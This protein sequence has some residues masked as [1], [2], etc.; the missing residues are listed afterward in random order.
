MC[1][2]AVLIAAAGCGTL[3][4]SGAAD[5]DAPGLRLDRSAPY[6]EAVQTP[7][8]EAAMPAVSEAPVATPVAPTLPAAPAPEAPAPA[9]SVEPAPAPGPVVSTG[10]ASYRLRPGDTIVI[11]LR[12][13]QLEQFEMIVD[14]NGD[15]KL[16]YIGAVRAAGM[17]GS[18]L[19]NQI[20]S[21][22]ISKKIYKY[23]TVHVLV[24]TRG[25]FVTGEV[26]MPGRMPLVGSV[27]ILQ[28]IATAGGYTDFADPSSVQLIRGGKTIKINAKDVARNRQKDVEIESGD[29]IKVERTW[30]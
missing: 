10:G 28:A 4:K 9:P 7:A 5:A 21:D 6:G 17:T 14:E 26:R 11:H 1:A 23:L 16:P 18:E 25:Y 29:V 30:Y 20:Q 8:T 15:V 2:A 3:G 19:E 27:S 12:T 13:T 22:Y 24:P